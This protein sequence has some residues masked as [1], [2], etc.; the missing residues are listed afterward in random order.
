M[1]IRLGITVISN[2]RRFTYFLI[3]SPVELELIFKCVIEGKSKE[4]S[5]VP[6]R[7]KELERRE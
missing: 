3:E 6:D 2:K 7:L 1:T 4:L 5:R